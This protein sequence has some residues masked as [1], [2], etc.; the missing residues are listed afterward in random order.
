MDDPPLGLYGQMS[1]G[2]VQTHSYQII[3]C[4]LRIEL[5]Q[6][7]SH[8]QNLMQNSAYPPWG[9]RSDVHGG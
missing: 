8:L 5:Y 1:V 2:K 3:E 7:C 4:R 6:Y 9:I